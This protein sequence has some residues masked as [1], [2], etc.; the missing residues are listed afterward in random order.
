MGPQGY[1][2]VLLAGGSGSNLFPLNQMNLPLALLPVANQP[3]ITYSLR[4]LEA[5]GIVEVLVV[6][7]SNGND[8]KFCY[9]VM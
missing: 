9:H 3:L 4:A 1:Q 7:I 2:A 5:A 8:G 6:G